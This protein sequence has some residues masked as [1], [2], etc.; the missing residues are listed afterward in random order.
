[1]RQ[2]RSQRRSQQQSASFTLNTAAQSGQLVVEAIEVN[3]SRGDDNTIIKDFSSTIL[4]GDKIGIIGPNGC[5]KSTL[6]QLLTGELEADSGSIKMGTR[7]EV[8]YLNQSRSDIREDQSLLDNISQGRSEVIVNKKPMHIMTYLQEFLFPPHR[9]QVPASALSGGERNRLMLA[10][11]FANPFNL[12]ILDEPTNDLDIDTLE[13][14][15]QKLVDYSGT[16][17]LVSHDRTFLNNIVT[18]TIVFEGEATLKEY[19]GG[20]DDWLRQNTSQQQAPQ[21]SNS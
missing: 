17:L 5:G 4:R 16:L 2:Q 12:L 8:A 10:K 20:Y 11:L 18:S 19:I 3:Y 9:A 14:L 6:I 7:L 13:L 15:E 1:M 21:N